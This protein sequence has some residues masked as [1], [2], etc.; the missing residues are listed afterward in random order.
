MQA[1]EIKKHKIDE[2]II[3]RSRRHGIT[4]YRVIDSYDMSTASLETTLADA[5]RTAAELNVMR[6]THLKLYA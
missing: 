1:T 5:I 6:N 4:Y 2:F 3:K